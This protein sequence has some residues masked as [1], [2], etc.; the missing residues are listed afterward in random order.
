[1]KPEDLVIHSGRFLQK[2]NTHTQ[3]FQYFSET[4]NGKR[5]NSCQMGYSSQMLK[6]FG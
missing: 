4:R 6:A 5:K 1:M 2:Y 3:L